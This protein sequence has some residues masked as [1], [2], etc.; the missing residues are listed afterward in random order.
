MGLIGALSSIVD[1]WTVARLLLDAGVRKLLCGR[2]PKV[3]I[4][5]TATGNLITLVE[6][7]VQRSA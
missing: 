3:P 1:G 4:R 2:A 5:T 7:F 6:L